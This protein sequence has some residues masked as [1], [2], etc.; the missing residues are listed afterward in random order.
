MHKLNACPPDGRI[1]LRFLPDGKHLAPAAD[2]DIWGCNEKFKAFPHEDFSAEF[3]PLINKRNRLNNLVAVDCGAFIGDHAQQ[4]SRHGMLTWAIEPFLDAFTCLCY[5][6]P[7]SHNILGVAGDG[8]KCRLVHECPGTN[9]GMR[10]VMEDPGGE[11]SIRIDDLNLPW[12]DL[13]K[14]DVEGC[15]E[16]VLDGAN[17]MIKRYRPVLLVESYDDVLKTHGSSKEKLESSLRSLGYTLKVLGDYN[18][19]KFDWL[20][21]YES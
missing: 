16:W 7:D 2:N 9:H 12:L 21:Y 8:R 4:F 3:V 10:Y 14:I 15:E 18:A 11:P 19:L 20:C 1:N 17:K 6:S 13:I 5:N